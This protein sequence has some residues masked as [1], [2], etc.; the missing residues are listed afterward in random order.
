MQF[1]ILLGDSVRDAILY[2]A[3]LLTHKSAPGLVAFLLLVVLAVAWAAFSR[4]VG[5]QR[6]A[7][8]WLRNLIAASASEIDFSRDI[9]TL[10]A[11]VRENA[12]SPQQRQVAHAWAEYRETLVP[13]D[14]DGTTIMRNAVRPS[15]FLNVEDLGFGAGAW[16]I[17]PGLFVTTGLFLTFLGLISALNAM[18]Q[19]DEINSATMR[20][21]LS[22]A[23]A[24]FI[25]SLTGLFCS[26]VF[27]IVFRRV[28]GTLLLATHKL[29]EEIERKLT[30]ISLEALAAEQLKATREQ[31]EHFRL[32]GMEL[33]AELG[34]PLREEL[35]KAISTSI[36]EAMAP[37]VDRV[38]KLGAEGV[39]DMVSGLSSKLT[40]TVG[41]ALSDAS[42]RLAEAGSKI[43][44][45]ADR[46][47]Q[48]SGRMGQ[49]MEAT[50]SRVAQAVEDLRSAMTATAQSTGGAFT[51]GAEQLLEVMNQTLEGIKSNTGEGAQAI[52]AAASE[53]R[54]AA[55]AFK[56]EIEA[57][58]KSGSEAAQSRLAAVATDASTSIGTA[59]QNVVDAFGKTSADIARIS[60]EA[61]LKVSREIMAPL[62]DIAAQLKEMLGG[63]NQGNSDLRRMAEGVRA[64][65]DASADAAGNFRAA[66]SDLVSAVTPMRSVTERIETSVR[67]LAESTQNVATAVMSSAES[68]ALSAASA[69]DA[70]KQILG[71]EARAIEAT[72]T[73]LTTLV[74]KMRNQ[75]DRLDEMD[76]KLGGAF[77]TYTDQVARAI[78]GMFGHV[79]DMQERLNP[80]LDT[81][82][83]I[84]EQAEQFS[85]QSRRA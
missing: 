37:V 35:P 55:E 62:E 52:S 84:V 58:A 64:G 18:S 32:I 50:A 27:T 8:A 15:T 28:Y 51:Q 53:M 30:Y 66:S 20:T 33:V 41:L 65:A 61:A 12:K 73:G 68:T 14:E 70:A 9:D 25:M 80:A 77:D 16:R 21:L 72:L 23:S 40:D 46:M 78:D 31:R 63:L 69:L 1:V 85:P 13:H 43:G 57:A 2:V 19:G 6:K 7:V 4:R 5:R 11:K 49:E 45:L 83:E 60:E 36:T 34:R 75:G 29:C 56:T 54:S 3:G 26:I 22:I 67:Q 10:S 48:S 24:K 59:G 81:M 82:R 42:Q 17:A 44:L 39:G 38:G 71:Q 76:T 79:R 47:D 74:E